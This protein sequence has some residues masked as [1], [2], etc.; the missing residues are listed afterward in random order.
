MLCFSACGYLEK[1]MIPIFIGRTGADSGHTLL[2]WSI[3]QALKDRGLNLGL[4]KPY[5][6]IRNR[7]S[8]ETAD[9]DVLLLA[10]QFNLKDPLERICPLVF[11]AEAPPFFSPEE[12]KSF[13]EKVKG[14]FHLL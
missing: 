9:R 14:S 13:E 11:P 1:E 2:A 7:D 6:T 3:G 5:G 10:E 8:G 4:F 12:S